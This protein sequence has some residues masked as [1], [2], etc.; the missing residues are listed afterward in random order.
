VEADTISDMSLVFQRPLVSCYGE[1]IGRLVQPGINICRFT[2]LGLPVY[3]SLPTGVSYRRQL[4]QEGGGFVV[5]MDDVGEVIPVVVRAVHPLSVTVFGSVARENR[6]NDLDLMIVVDRSQEALR[7]VEIVLRAALKPFY[8]RFA[9]DP[10]VFTKAAVQRSSAAG[11]PFMDAIAH[12]GKVVYMDGIL[13][14]WVRQAR[15]EL[16]MAR[17]LL[18]GGYHRGAC[19]HAQQAVEKRIKAHLL[20]AG[21]RLEKTHNIERLCALAGEYRIAPALADDDIAFLDSIYRGRYPAE[22]GLLPMG[23]PSKEDAERACAIAAAL[24]Q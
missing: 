12:E 20:K 24:V 10:F 4:P 23:D 1:V 18:E 16:G 11:S 15:D 21:W 7:D 14:D 2:S 22:Q 6:G 5:T 13:D 3:V 19:F 9:I 8:R 17:C